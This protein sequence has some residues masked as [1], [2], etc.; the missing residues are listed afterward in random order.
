M[1]L[2][3]LQKSC[4]G[5]FER[6]RASSYNREHF[7]F[8]SHPEPQGQNRMQAQGKGAD[9]GEGSCFGDSHMNHSCYEEYSARLI[10]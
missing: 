1:L 7:G 6:K 9:F 3:Q 5:Q 10:P 8:H 4:G 2:R